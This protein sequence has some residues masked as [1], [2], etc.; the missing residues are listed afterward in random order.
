MTF[1]THKLGWLARL[2]SFRLA[3]GRP[4]RLPT[5]RGAA[6][7]AVGAAVFLAIQAVLSGASAVTYYVNDPVY[8]DKERRL[9]RLERAA[10]P[11]AT[12][13]ML[14]GTSRTG[15]AYAA[16]RTQR[17]A[18][19]AGIPAVAFNF[20]IPGAGP[21]ANRLSLSRLIADGH[22]PDLLIL[23][24]LPP[25]LAD[26]P[27]GPL[28]ARIITGDT[29]SRDEIAA[30]DHYGMPTERLRKQ[31]RRAALA[32]AFV[33]RFKLLSRIFPSAVPWQ[34]R[35]D[36]GRTQDPNG[37][38]PSELEEVDAEQR[39][40]GVESTAREY[41]DVVRHELPA[42]PAVDALRDTLVLCRE[43]GITVALV[44]M[45]ESTSF[46]ALY[47][48]GAEEK[49]QRFLRGLTAEFGCTLTDARRWLPDDAFLD[50]HHSL[51][52]GAATF[53]DRFTTETILPLLRRHAG[54]GAAT[55]KPLS[56]GGKP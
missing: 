38:N 20:G 24:V 19:D 33:H 10:P 7:V 16:G 22:K 26:L 14:L 51:R 52:A 31:W 54:G 11:G 40:R 23:E 13:V 56:A 32:P 25:L 29:L 15:F 6:A 28:E 27:G 5:R 2:L 50:G 49:V 36:W 48:P 8:A 53:T 9:R 47:P 4:A 21:V 34:L 1:A 35:Y 30:A 46:G 42:G 41:R 39:A 44:I 18:E 3:G 55:L 17:A 45:P 12:R 37:W 43:Q